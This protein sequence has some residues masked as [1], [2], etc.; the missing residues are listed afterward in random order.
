MNTDLRLAI[1]LKCEEPLCS[2][3]DS[4]RPPREP[5]QGRRKKTR[6]AN[7]AGKPVHIYFSDEPLLRD[8]DAKQLTPLRNFQRSL[9]SEGL[10]GSQ[11]GGQPGQPPALASL[12]SRA[13]GN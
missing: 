1:T 10:H 7:A 4:A 2:T 9:E 11:P 12:R 6:R 13:L 8:V 3:P 5:F